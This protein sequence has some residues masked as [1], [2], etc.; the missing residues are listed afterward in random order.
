MSKQKQ[1]PSPDFSLSYRA[2]GVDIEAGN[3]LVQ[4]IKPAA[5]R[6]ARPG[7]LS[8]LGGFGSLFELPVNRY[9]HP[10]LVAGTDGVG[11][12]LKLAIQLNRHQS[13]GIDLVA[14]CVN[15]IVV[16]GAEPLFFLDYYATGQLEVDVA[17]EIIEGI[18]HGCELAG[19]AL[20]GGETAEMPGI[21]QAGDYDLAG[22]GV[23]VVEKERLIDG[24][25]VQAGDSLIGIASSG[26]HAN[27]YSLIRKVLEHSSY[28]LDSPFGEQTLGDA[29]LTPTRIYVKPLLQLL[30]TIEV[31]ALAHITGG[32]LPENLPRVLPPGLSAEIETSRWPRP[33]IFNWLQQQ[34]HLPEKELYLTFN[35]GIGMV[36][37]VDQTD[38]E[39]T[40]ELLSNLGETAWLIGQVVPKGNERPG[41]ILNSG[42]QS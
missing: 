34:G 22:F 32:G 3:R 23:G 7:V 26:P 13:I 27:G 8:G 18:A 9:R 19:A 42:S 6:T 31:H 25:R 21:Y 29:L 39:Q 35:C 37:C 40:L 4:R 38:A 5:A 10:I 24:S 15:D 33:P 28:S 41:V 36:V 30:E 16:Q 11:T 17:A 20:V 12:K 14:M 1:S 2:A